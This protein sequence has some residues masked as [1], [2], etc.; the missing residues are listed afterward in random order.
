[1]VVDLT[2]LMETTLKS[3]YYASKVRVEQEKAT[4]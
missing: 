4:T 3:D 2:D 1:M